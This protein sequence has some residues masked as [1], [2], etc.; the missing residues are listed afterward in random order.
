MLSIF[1]RDR[2]FLANPDVFVTLVD[3]F[4]NLYTC[5]DSIRGKVHIQPRRD[6]TL[7][8]VTVHLKGKSRAFVQTGS[9]KNSHTISCRGSFL[10]QSKTVYNQPI[11]VSGTASQGLGQGEIRDFQFRFPFE[12]SSFLAKQDYTIQPHD[13]FEHLPG[14]LPPPT[15]TELGERIFV[16]YF[17]KLV[18]IK[19]NG[20]K[21]KEKIPLR[22]CPSRPVLDPNP[23]PAPFRLSLT[24]S[25][26]QLDAGTANEHLSFRGKISRTMH[27]EPRHAT[28]LFSFTGSTPTVTVA[29]QPLSIPLQISYDK[30]AST[31]NQRPDIILRFV[32]ARLTAYTYYRVP[33][34]RWRKREYVRHR[35]LKVPIRQA[36]TPI[37]VSDGMVQLDQLISPLATSQ[38]QCPSFRTYFF[39]RSYK[40]KISLVILCANKESELVIADHPLTILPAPFR[41]PASVVR[42]TPSPGLGRG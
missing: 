11:T 22:F 30:Y 10:C 40:L 37:P 9:G 25:N 16:E 17:L 35:E 31:A 34:K 39:H 29:G 21:L 36:P 26:K 27:G 18:A 28:A 32:F 6:L 2:D 20:K 42:S 13:L 41:D 14:H 1:Q 7:N 8:N 19:T 12:V 3:P 15:F 38:Q 24:R 23:S 5:G 4:E 33:S